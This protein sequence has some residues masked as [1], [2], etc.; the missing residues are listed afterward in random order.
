MK[1]LTFSVGEE[2]FAVRKKNDA[3]KKN[4]CNN[5]NI[6]LIEWKYTEEINKFI[7]DKKLIKYKEKLNGIYPFTSL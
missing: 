3:I 7:L 1:P 6:I 5:C 2:G 4:I